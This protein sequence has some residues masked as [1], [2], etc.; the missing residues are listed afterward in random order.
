MLAPDVYRGGNSTP[1]LDNNNYWHCHPIYRWL[2]TFRCGHSGPNISCITIGPPRL[3]CK[4]MA[5]LVVL[6]DHT[7]PLMEN[8]GIS[9]TIKH[10]LMWHAFLSTTFD[11]HMFLNLCTTSVIQ[12]FHSC[13][14]HASIQIYNTCYVHR[15][16]TFSCVFYFTLQWWSI[17]LLQEKMTLLI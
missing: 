9:P 14:C 4:T 10:M 17:L 13:A 12:T 7:L 8:T 1:R 15:C 5:S 3:C 11:T 6:A 2:C 16:G